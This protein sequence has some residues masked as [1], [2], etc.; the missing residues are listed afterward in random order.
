MSAE[1]FAN[2]ATTTLGSSLSSGAT[3]ATVAVGT[4]AL[5]P[6][7]SGSEYF[8][9]TLWAAGNTTGVPNE[10]VKVTARSG[11]TMTIVRAQEGTTALSWNVGDT[12]ANY[13]TAAYLNALAQ[14][15]DIQ[16][17][18]GN[19]ADDAG[20]ANGGIVTLN[21]V[22]ASLASLTGSPIGVLK[23]GFANTGSYTLD[24][25]GLGGVPVVLP[26]GGALPAGALLANS[27]F[28]VKYDGTDFELQSP[29]A[30]QG[31]LQ[32]VT[33]EVTATGAFS[34]AIDANAIPGS[35]YG[36]ATGPG[37]GA[38]GTTSGKT[39]GAGGAGG[40]A[41]GPI[42]LTPGGNLTGFNGTGG[43]GGATGNDGN[44][45]SAATTCGALTGNPGGLGNFSASV[46]GG[47]GGS[48]SGGVVNTPGGWG[49]DGLLTGDTGAW[50]C[51]GASFWGGGGRAGSGGGENGAAPGSGGGAGYGSA[52]TGGNG[53]NGTFVLTY[54]KILT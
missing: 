54:W 26:G 1:Q 23:I 8:T 20:T 43:L 52:S 9:A 41:Q 21:P 4:G 42:A 38:A 15:P 47:S 53:A 44:N 34:I 19:F 39:G 40:T 24:V 12:F 22:P 31:I 13:P 28:T 2:N 35:G 51:G 11:D 30:L 18:A 25:N 16:Q 3:T 7:I 48:A 32:L 36:I 46:A 29:P 37:G 45:G 50:A 6:T 14:Q 5:F 10:I 49:T 17:Q 33:V 27:I